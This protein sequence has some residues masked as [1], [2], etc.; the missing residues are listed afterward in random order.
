VS[1]PAAVARTVARG[2]GEQVAALRA[3]LAAGRP[4]AGWKLGITDLRVQEHLGLD[5]PVVGPLRGDRLLA[6]GARFP[7]E[8]GAALRVEVE[9][10][11]R[12]ACDVDGAGGLPAARAAIGALAP[13]LE[14]VDYAAPA[15]DL[16]GVLARNTFHAGLVLGG[17]RADRASALPG[18]LRARIR[19]NGA[20]AG[21]TVPAWVPDDFAALLVRAA[22][23][24]AAHG[25]ALRAGDLVLSGA[26]TKPLAVSAGDLVEGELVGLGAVAVSFG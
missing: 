15:A 24:L 6:S 8:P 13:A 22:S 18:E 9:V 3:A 26:Y 14:I 11:I 4:R 12:L 23:L 5:G 17:E 10:A 16:A 7:L 1:D 21:E 25:E 2:I 19:K 20:L